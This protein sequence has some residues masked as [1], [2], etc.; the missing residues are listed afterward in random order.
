MATYSN[1]EIK[2][3]GFLRTALAKEAS[4][5]TIDVD[6]VNEDDTS[7]AIT[8]QSDTLMFEIDP[9]NKTGK[10]S[11]ICLAASNASDTPQ[12]DRTRFTTVVRGISKEG[13]E[14]TGSATRARSWDEG[15]EVAIATGTM[16]KMVNKLMEEVGDALQDDNEA[17]QLT[18]YATTTT[19][20]AAITAPSNGDMCYVTA[21][22]TAMIY[23]GGAW[24]NVDTGAAKVNASTTVSGVVEIATVAEQGSAAAAG[25]TGAIAVPT[26]GNLVKTSSGAGDENKMAVLDAAGAWADGFISASSV[27]QHLTT[28]MTTGENVTAG[29]ALRAK[30]DGLVY[31]ADEDPVK[32]MQRTLPA[33]VEG[34]DSSGIAS[35]QIATDKTVVVWHDGA[36]I[37]AQVFIWDGEQFTAGTVAT[38]DATAGAVNSNRAID[39]ISHATDAFTV[40][41][42]DDAA[43]GVD[44]A[45]AWACTV[46]TTTITAGTPQ[47]IDAGT[48]TQGSGHAVCSPA[49]GKVAMLIDDTADSKV[50]LIVGTIA[51]RTFTLGSAVE[52]SAAACDQYLDITE[53]GTDKV[54]S[55][56]RDADDD[57]RARVATISTVTCTQGTEVEITDAITLGHVYVEKVEDDKFVIC[58]EEAAADKTWLVVCTV[59]G[60]TIT[61]GTPVEIGARG[62]LEIANILYFS[63]N[64]I[65]IVY[66]DDHGIETHDGTY[67]YTNWAVGWITTAA[68][69]PTVHQIAR[70]DLDL[71][72]SGAAA[73]DYAP[74]LVKVND[75]MIQV[76]WQEITTFYIYTQNIADNNFIGYANSTITSGNSVEVD[77]M[78]NSSQTGLT[79]GAQ[80]YLADSGAIATTGIVPCGTAVSATKIIK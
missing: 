1:I 47:V 19:R 65:A 34:V 35:C 30:I 79:T 40:V 33:G 27:N 58:Y 50:N 73:R 56:Y 78:F 57:L 52:V 18:V 24:A 14:Q 60:T 44:D 72:V 38:I 59:S 48:Q 68:T 43:A 67:P 76:V 61:K 54:V 31:K 12:T 46:A 6:F 42:W 11:E 13:H 32:G 77:L 63:D 41:Q 15:T 10:G 53:I 9:L 69:V 64:K 51:T 70:L 36:V 3:K 39:V 23:Q 2:V 66:A 45:T 17:L 5:T 25:G 75:D 26:V 22:G 37:E 29:N 8:L 49:S 7:T 71:G 28:P 20:D 74:I 62:T 21:E 55:V 16:A 4:T 80:Y